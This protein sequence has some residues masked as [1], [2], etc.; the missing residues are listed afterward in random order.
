MLGASVVAVVVATAAK[1]G[2]GRPD[3]VI[4]GGI[5]CAAAE[6]LCWVHDDSINKARAGSSGKVWYVA[7]LCICDGFYSIELSER[8]QLEPHCQRIL[9]SGVEV[10]RF[11]WMGDERRPH[12]HLADRDRGIVE[13]LAWEHQIGT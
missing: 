2:A 4:C 1:L 3:K 9:D 7:R 13:T 10:R 5:A 8:R 11:V 6:E 12:Q